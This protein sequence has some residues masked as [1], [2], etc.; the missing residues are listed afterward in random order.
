VKERELQA[1]ALQWLMLRCNMNGSIGFARG[2]AS[3]ICC[4]AAN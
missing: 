1:A 3:K 4:A 2:I